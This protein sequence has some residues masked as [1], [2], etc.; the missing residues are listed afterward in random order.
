MCVSPL[1]CSMVA[2][3]SRGIV[4]PNVSWLGRTVRAVL[5]NQTAR[6]E[7]EL[8]VPVGLTQFLA[9]RRSVA[10]V[11]GSR[12]LVLASPVRRLICGSEKYPLDVSC[13][14]WASVA[15]ARAG[16]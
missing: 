1:A 2:C 12:L 5:Y 3:A 14:C 4:T 13:R 9:M 8:F 7:R 6:H 10:L 15:T 16:Y 11:S